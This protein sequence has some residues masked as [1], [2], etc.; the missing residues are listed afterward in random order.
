MKNKNYLVAVLAVLLV[1]SIGYAL[2]GQTINITGSAKAQGS[3]AITT[4]C[5]PGL[6]D[7]VKEFFGDDAGDNGYANDSCTVTGNNVSYHADLLYP[8][9]LRSYTVTMTNT[10]SMDAI[11]NINTGIRQ[12]KNDVCI[13]GGTGSGSEKN[14]TIEAS[15]C[16]DIKNDLEAIAYLSINTQYG[17]HL[18]SSMIILEDENGNLITDDLENYYNSETG[19]ITL[20]PGMSFNVIP[21]LQIPSSM[22]GS[23]SFLL[24]QEVITE[25]DFNQPTAQ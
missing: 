11:L 12:I 24:T 14:G 9:A 5:T 21:V 13:D 17:P 8:G 18:D 15:E 1:V 22:N 6:T 25:F 16:R 4:T 19:D 23:G 3:F 2:F 7:G 10:G 20:E